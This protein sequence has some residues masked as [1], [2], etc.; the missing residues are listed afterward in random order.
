MVESEIADPTGE[1]K[2]PEKDYSKCKPQDSA[3]SILGMLGS[4]SV[5]HMAEYERYPNV[6]DSG[7][8]I[9][10]MPYDMK[11]QDRLWERL[12]KLGMEGDLQGPE[13]PSYPKLS[14]YH[15]QNE[16]NT[17]EYVVMVW[18]RPF[19]LN[20]TTAF[21]LM[22][23]SKGGERKEKIS[24][25]AREAWQPSDS[26]N[27]GELKLPARQRG[28]PIAKERPPSF[29]EK[30]R[31]RMD[32]M[33]QWF[34]CTPG[35]LAR[36]I[37]HSD[38]RIMRATLA[39]ILTGLLPPEL[40]YMGN[41]MGSK[42]P[43]GGDLNQNKSSFD[44][45]DIDEES[46]SNATLNNDTKTTKS[47]R[48]KWDPEI[49]QK[50]EGFNESSFLDGIDE[51]WADQ[52]L[53]NLTKEYQNGTDSKDTKS[54]PDPLEIFNT[55]NPDYYP[56]TN[57]HEKY[58]PTDDYKADYENPL[59]NPKCKVLPQLEPTLTGKPSAM[60]FPSHNDAPLN[61]MILEQ[62]NSLPIGK[63]PATPRDE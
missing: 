28:L 43:M 7:F 39:Q 19:L 31:D 33:S 4:D 29:S 6:T 61:E 46:N 2:T 16:T 12:M 62:R 42:G 17:E 9:T 49:D 20:S 53:K 50:S 44:F 11:W 32:R 21:E 27:I 30:L 26:Q 38:Q 54:F 59:Y 58:R 22:S 55:S 48:E 56:D 51:D 57:P 23:K 36:I 5:M 15:L 41:M 52:F 14:Y 60:G 40:E 34:G 8:E 1:V 25:L 47:T 13:L 35:D 10:C 3:L 18:E 24:F 37:K 63:K 45:P